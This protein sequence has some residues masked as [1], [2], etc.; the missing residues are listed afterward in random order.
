MPEPG[1]LLL[2]GSGLVALGRWRSA[3]FSLCKEARVYA[4]IPLATH[5]A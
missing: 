3:P 1:S 2:L 5:G 4:T